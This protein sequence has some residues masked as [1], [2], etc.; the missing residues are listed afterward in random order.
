MS[1]VL[2]AAGTAPRPRPVPAC[3]ACAS[4]WPLAS[5][6]SSRNLEQGPAHR[7]LGVLVAPLAHPPAP[8]E[9]LEQATPTVLQ[10]LPRR[11]HAARISVL[12]CRPV[13][14][15]PA[16]PIGTTARV[17]MHCA[18]AHPRSSASAFTSLERT[19]TRW[20][21]KPA[22][23]PVTPMR[24]CCRPPSPVRRNPAALDPLSRSQ[25]LWPASAARKPPV[26][27]SAAARWSCV[28]RGK[29][30]NSG[31]KCSSFRRATSRCRSWPTSWAS[32]AP[33]SSRASSS[34]ASSPR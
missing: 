3:L 19:T 25:P 23:T 12:P 16:A 22:A 33:R 24:W 26:S 21:H 11:H 10:P 4:R 34:R 27:V 30:S 20:P 1:A 6:C 13:A 5:S 8:P 32:R 9:P 7:R 17:W 14:A 2:V 31:P 28:P 18:A 15:V 29:P